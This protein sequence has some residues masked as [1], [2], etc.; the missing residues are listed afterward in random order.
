MDLIETILKWVVTYNKLCRFRGKKVFD[1]SFV[2]SV[3]DFYE[4]NGFITQYQEAA[5]INIITKF[6]IKEK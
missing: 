1:T 3:N 4:E 5:L 2:E 6:K